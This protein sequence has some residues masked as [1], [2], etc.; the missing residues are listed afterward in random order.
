MTP[1]KIAEISEPIEVIYEK[2]VDE[3]L[4]NIAK[5]LS[6]PNNT[7]TALHEVETLGNMGALTRENI[8]IINRYVKM[9]P[10]AVKSALNESRLVALG[11]IEEKLQ[12]AAENGYLTQPVTD[13]TVEVTKAF[14]QQAVDQLNL[15]NQTV[16]NSSLDAY[17]SG[18]YELRQGMTTI[19]NEQ[20]LQEAQDLID[21]RAGM[22]IEGTESRTSALRKTLIRLNEK[23]ITGFFDRA[24]RSW[25]AE[26]YVNMD[27][28][29]TVHNT[30]IQSIRARQEDYGSDVF[31]VSAHAGARPL[32]YPYQ[33]KMYSWGGM[34]GYITLGDGKKYRF[35]SINTTSY[36]KPAGLF[37]INCGHV[38]YPMIPSV[39]EPVDEKI[40]M[41]KENDQEYQESQ[42]QRSLERKIRYY[43]REIQMLGNLATDEDKQ[44]LKNA[45]ADMRQFIKETGRTRRYDREQIV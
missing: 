1:N 29:T 37:G 40:P 25:S 39:S 11:E 23:G 27:I 32:C 8:E 44:K 36:G 9:M 2:M 43:K 34:G 16:L 20:M 24:G 33:G 3:L 45:Q 26:A 6:D 14:A 4:L 5:H 21:L 13:G 38:P 42:E 31:Q 19:M 15:V 35:E 18:M 28:R 30:Y 7:W 10:E 41:K 12:K 22:T 17:Q